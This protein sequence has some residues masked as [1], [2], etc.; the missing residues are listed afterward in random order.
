MDAL[1]SFVD[2]PGVPLVKIGYDCRV[3]KKAETNLPL[4]QTRYA[5]LGATTKQGQRWEIPVCVKEIYETGNNKS[6]VLLEENIQT[7]FAVVGPLD[8]SCPVVMPNADGAGYYR[9]T[10]PST[11]WAALLDKIDKLNTREVLATQDSLLAAYRAG[12][13]DSVVYLRGVEKFANHPEYDVVNKAGDLLGFMD[14]HLPD[15]ARSDYERFVRDIYEAKYK[16][17]VGTDTIEGQ[18]LAPTLLGNLIYRAN[19]KALVSEYALKGAAYLGL[20]GDADTSAVPS[21]LLSYALD[22]A[23][24]EREVEAFDSLLSLHENGSRREKN[25]ALSAL[26]E[27]KSPERAQRLLDMALDESSQMNQN[28]AASIIFGLMG[29]PDHADMTWNWFKTNFDSYVGKR[30][31]DVRKPGIAAFGGGFCATEKARELESL[32][33]SKADQIPGYERRLAQTLESIELCAALKDAKIK[34]LSEALK[35]R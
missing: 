27:V 5:P 4:V 9:F 12:E 31:P 28:D 25:S 10:M 29:K 19:D 1:K 8:G 7:D 13:V 20:D 23:M 6:C 15:S 14:N 24:L 30:V 32:I 21:N 2:Q 11:S 16:S 34:E 22:A 35:N 3:D 17:V 33:E 18:L 26:V